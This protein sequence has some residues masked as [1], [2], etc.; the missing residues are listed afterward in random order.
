M[1]AYMRYKHTETMSRPVDMPRGACVGSVDDSGSKEEE[2]VQRHR[3]CRLARR[4]H[5]SQGLV[6]QPGVPPASQGDL[7]P[8]NGATLWSCRE[9]VGM[10]RSCGN[11]WYFF[12]LR[13][14]SMKSI[15]V[16]E[17]TKK[18]LHFRYLLKTKRKGSYFIK[19]MCGTPLAYYWAAF[20]LATF[21]GR[22]FPS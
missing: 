3:V 15:R 6:L 18:V 14:N 9:S 12:C 5:L 11:G 13:C 1:C 22:P 17:R 16:I 19:H 20:F 8:R 7:G 10:A 2:R 4:E 21:T